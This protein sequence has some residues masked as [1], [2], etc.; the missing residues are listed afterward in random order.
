MTNIHIDLRRIIVEDWLTIP[1]QDKFKQRAMNILNKWE[2]LLLNNLDDCRW[3]R[4]ESRSPLRR[5]PCDHLSLVYVPKD[6]RHGERYFPAY[7][8][9]ISYPMRYFK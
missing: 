9:V 7:R 5:R 3:A 4:V 8:E 6:K 2:Q 1:G